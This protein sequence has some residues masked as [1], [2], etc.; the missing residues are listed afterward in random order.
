MFHVKHGK[1][2]IMTLKQLWNSMN[3]CAENTKVTLYYEG[4]AYDYTGERWSKYF[5]ESYVVSYTYNFK[6][7]ALVV[8]LERTIK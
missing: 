5:A 3:F 4:S 6:V 7:N 2:G 1:D 8:L